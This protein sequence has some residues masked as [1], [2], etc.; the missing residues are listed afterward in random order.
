MPSPLHPAL[1]HFPIVLILLGTLVALPAVVTP[2]WNLRWI[3]AVLL[4]LGAIGTAAALATGEEDGEA[5]E[6][7]AGVEAVLDQHENWAQRTQGFSIAAGLC[8]LAAAAATLRWPTLARGIGAASAIVALVATF[9]VVQT[10]HYGGQL[11]YR[12]G[13]GVNLA[14]PSNT[15]ES[16]TPSAPQTDRARGNNGA[17]ADDDHR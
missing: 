8:A 14:P 17:E 9:C 4:A 11:V 3:A 2:R 1:V 13:A 5:V 12:H 15:T 16:G 7:V 10:G 6:Q